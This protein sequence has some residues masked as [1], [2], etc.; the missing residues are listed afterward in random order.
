ME[1]R[2]KTPGIK[3]CKEE[4]KEIIRDKITL[5]MAVVMAAAEMRMLI[6]EHHSNVEWNF[7]LANGSIT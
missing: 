2:V 1:T 7:V 3:I 6:A 4:I 5:I